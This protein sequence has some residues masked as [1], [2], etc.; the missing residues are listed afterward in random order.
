MLCDCGSYR[1]VWEFGRVYIGIKLSVNEGKVVVMR[2]LSCVTG[3][4]KCVADSKSFEEVVCLKFLGPEVPV[5][6]GCE[7]CE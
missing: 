6:G 4:N 7:K 2:G 3:S 1:L 5:D